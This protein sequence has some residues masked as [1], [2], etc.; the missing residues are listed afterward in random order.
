MN[1]IQLMKSLRSGE[2]DVRLRRLYGA[3][4]QAAAA[5]LCALIDRHVD[6]FG[7]GDMMLFSAPGRTEIGGN[8]T[9]HN[10]GSVLTAAI[11][12]DMIAVAMRSAEPY[13]RVSSPGHKA[14]A[15]DL[16]SLLPRAGERGT[17]AAL[18]RGMAASL[19][20]G[21]TPPGGIAASV[22]SQ[23]D[24]GSGLSSSAAF[25]VLIGLI[26]DH[27]YGRGLLPPVSLAKSARRAETEF[28][29]KPV[30]LMDQM[31]CT[32]GGMIA[33]DFQDPENPV[34][35][36][37]DVDFSAFGYTLCISGPFDSHATL[38]DKYAAIP[39]EMR[40][41]AR[42]LGGH[43]LRDV[44]PEAFY[45][46]LPALRQTLPG[47]AL[48]RAHH[49]FSENDRVEKLVAALDDT[50]FKAFLRLINA[51]GRSSYMYLQNVCAEP[52][53]TLALAL[54]M[55]ERILSGSGATRVHGGG[56]AGTIQAFVPHLLVGDYMNQMD[57]LFG[58]AVSRALTIRPVGAV[59]VV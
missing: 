24:S 34:V 4:A 50:D 38:T 51:S 41:V 20:E 13:F 42:A 14:I 33:I 5:R 37:M 1:A 6:T 40:D 58:R 49:F 18:V 47:R 11:N 43:V 54:A 46:A 12:L 52:A 32:H 45:G 59:R 3:Q 39:R 35:R 29:G 28:F 26:L 30:G 27:L 21:G 31:A 7:D 8:H 36:Q 57:A 23:V 56:F 16:G 2:H 9:D 25:T 19:S 22:D 10:H 53:Q 55:S 44:S 15:V 48:L 17:S